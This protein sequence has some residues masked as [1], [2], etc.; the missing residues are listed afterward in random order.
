MIYFIIYTTWLPVNSSGV[1]N[2]FVIRIHPDKKGDK[3]LLAH[4]LLHVEQFWNNPLTHGLRYRFSKA[5]RLDC[6]AK[7]YRIQLSYETDPATYARHI[8][9]YA[10]W[11]SDPSPVTGYGLTLT[12][13]EALKLLS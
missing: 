9:L 6:E 8:D 3:G 10:T 7:A 2:A 5:Y 13:D 12:K 1:A 11:L 4:E